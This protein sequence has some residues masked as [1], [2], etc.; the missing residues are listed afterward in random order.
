M[1]NDPR[2]LDGAIYRLDL[3]AEEGG[4][5]MSTAWTVVK[6]ELAAANDERARQRNT[7]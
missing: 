6:G 2:T 5:C 1:T 4:Y 3:S 7:K